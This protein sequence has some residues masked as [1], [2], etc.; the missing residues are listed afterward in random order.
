MSRQHT[1]LW[2][3]GHARACR[4]T[5]RKL[6]ACRWKWKLVTHRMT[7]FSQNENWSMQSIDKLRN[8]SHTLALLH[9]RRVLTALPTSPVATGSIQWQCPPNFV[10]SRRNCFER[11]IKTEIFPPQTLK[12]GYDPAAHPRVSESRWFC[13]ARIRRKR[14]TG[15]A[16]ALLAARSSKIRG[17]IKL[18]DTRARLVQPADDFGGEEGGNYN[19]LLYEQLNMFL[20]ISGK[21]NCPVADLSTTAQK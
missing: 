20:K 17:R 11:T 4:S 15:R 3:F 10:V 5:Q 12:P 19:L 21:G 9:A 7:E 1:K 13:L 2:N 16:W 18:V 8:Q 14:A 6:P